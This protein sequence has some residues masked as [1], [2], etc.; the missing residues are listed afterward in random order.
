MPP[1]IWMF[2]RTLGDRFTE[3]MEDAWLEIFG[4]AGSITLKFARGNG[5]SLNAWRRMT[6]SGYL[7]DM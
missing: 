1:L 6:L 3:D 2:Q 5:I 7:E 4:E